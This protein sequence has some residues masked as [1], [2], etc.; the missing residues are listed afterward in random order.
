MRK[1]NPSLAGC[2]HP[3][4]W[5]CVRVIVDKKC[6]FKLRQTAYALLTDNAPSPAHIPCIVVAEEDD[7]HDEF[8]SVQ[9]MT[10]PNQAGSFVTE[11]VRTGHALHSFFLERVGA[12]NMAGDFEEIAGIGENLSKKHYNVY[13]NK[14]Q[15]EALC[16][17]G[18]KES[19]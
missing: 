19:L 2:E 12:L 1:H 17:L 18:T 15:H 14:E 6:G 10:V 5:A 7:N 3:S 16:S 4:V 8:Y 11:T 13:I 9:V